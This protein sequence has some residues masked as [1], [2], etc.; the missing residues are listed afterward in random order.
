MKTLTQEDIKHINEICPYEQGIFIQPNHIP[1]NI[2]EPV[3]FMQWESSGRPG[4]CWDDDD[5]VNEEYF[6]EFNLQEF[7]V[8]HLILEKLDKTIDNA[9]LESIIHHE[10]E[11]D[12]TS[13]GYYGDYENDSVTWILL[14]D[15][16]KVLLLE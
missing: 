11:F 6:N 15:L 5:T 8:L 4:S 7:K 2:K 10:P 14:S 16:Y 3:I 1:T 13:N 9:T 12:N